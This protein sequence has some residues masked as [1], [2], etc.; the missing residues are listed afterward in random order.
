MSKGKIL[1]ID[2]E[3]NIRLT[4]NKC[5]KFMDMEVE[6][7]INGEEAL[8]KFIPDKYDLVFL[9]LKMQGMNGMD[10]LKTIREK[11]KETPVVVVSAHG[12]VD[13]AVE[14]MKNGAA[15]FMQKPF[16][17]KEIHEK[18]EEI[19]SRKE[20][21]P[22]DIDTYE[23]HVKYARQLIG[24]KELKKAMEELKKAIGLDPLKAEPHQLIGA[25]LE[26]QGDFPEA[27]KH[28]EASLVMD[29][30]FLPAQMGLVRV[31]KK[32]KGQAD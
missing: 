23:A 27:K 10:V 28:Y 29:P 31:N 24:K 32:M 17:P 16:T 12:T 26:I 11:D 6:E 25:L 19:L 21:V 30:G 3:K 1:V 20:L 13:V 14:A 8:Q 5:L 9:D 2:D 4:L 18:V 22:E 7:A 15:D